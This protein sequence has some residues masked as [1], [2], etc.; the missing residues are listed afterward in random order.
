MAAVLWGFLTTPNLIGFVL[1]FFVIAIAHRQFNNMGIPFN[2]WF[3]FIML[4]PY[5]I[6]D[7]FAPLKWAIVVGLLGGLL[8]GFLSGMFTGTDDDDGGE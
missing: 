2:K 7:L 5:F 4:I 3:A 6:V 1:I 8:A